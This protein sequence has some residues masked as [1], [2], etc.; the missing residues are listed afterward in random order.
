MALITCTNLTHSYDN[1]DRTSYTTASVTLTAGNL[2]ILGVAA[3]C[4]APTASPTI[5]GT[6]SWVEVVNKTNIV[7]T[8]RVCMFACIPSADA[9]GTITIGFGAVTQVGCCWSVE[10]LTST[11][12]G[13]TGSSAIVQSSGAT[14]ASSQTSVTT[15]LSTFGNTQNATYAYGA[16]Q[17]NEAISAGSGFTLTGQDN[18]ATPNLAHI[19]QFKNTNDTSAEIT[20]TTTNGNA[21]IVAAEIASSRYPK[22]ISM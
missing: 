5:S 1:V 8:L 21:A 4:P 20:W 14:L 10:Q 7:D 13:P 11:A 19:G 3:R 17:N 22:I 18:G 9:T 15:T 6:G 12:T 2:H 16:V